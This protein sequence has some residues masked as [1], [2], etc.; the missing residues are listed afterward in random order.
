[1]KTAACIAPSALRRIARAAML[2]AAL[3]ACAPPLAH[4]QAPPPWPDSFVTRLG[5]LALIQSLN[6]EILGS[7]SATLTL[8]SW[9]RNHGLAEEPR[10]T[11]KSDQRSPCA[12]TAA[13]S[14]PDALFE[15]RAI[16]YTR[17]HQPFAASG[18]CWHFA[19]RDPASNPWLLH[20]RSTQKR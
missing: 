20:P 14:I 3:A 9:C 1:M 8:D 18:S 19:R 10:I 4:A 7:R 2:A 17:D 13:L 16:L 6:A 5:A 11:A 12:A 15:H